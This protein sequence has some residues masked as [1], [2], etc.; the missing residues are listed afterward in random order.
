MS[1]SGGRLAIMWDTT[2]AAVP[3]SVAN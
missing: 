1:D 2:M 3:F